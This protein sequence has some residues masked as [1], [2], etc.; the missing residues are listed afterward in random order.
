MSSAKNIATLTGETEFIDRP[1]NSSTG[2]YYYF[3][4][5]I[6]RVGEESAPTAAKSVGSLTDVEGDNL[7]MSWEVSMAYPN[8]FNPT[9]QVRFTLPVTAQVTAQVIDIQGRVVLDFGNNVYTAGS[10]QLE[11]N[12]R[13]WNSGVYFLRIQSPFGEQM[14]KMTLLK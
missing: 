7:P 10:H 6:N 13:N 9:T 8:P 12:A 11:L 2:N 4:T 1:A 5:E 3:V 14:R